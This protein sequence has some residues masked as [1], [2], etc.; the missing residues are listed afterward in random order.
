MKKPDDRPN[1]F[2]A[3]T[4]SHKKYFLNEVSNAITTFEKDTGLIVKKIKIIRDDDQVKIDAR[5]ELG[6]E[7]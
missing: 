3:G 1:Q 4:N 6:G 5:I 7:S 2:I